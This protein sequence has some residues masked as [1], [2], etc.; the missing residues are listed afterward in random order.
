MNIII[1]LAVGFCTLVVVLSLLGFI[2]FY[3]MSK[4]DPHG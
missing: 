1:G 4:D 3:A 2:A